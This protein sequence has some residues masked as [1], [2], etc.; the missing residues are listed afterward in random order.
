MPAVPTIISGVMQAMAP[1]SDLGTVV[2][3]TPVEHGRHR[4]KCLIPFSLEMYDSFKTIL[5]LPEPLSLSLSL[6]DD[7][8]LYA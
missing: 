3:L 8:V 1:I 2:D 7:Q 4:E 6:C 5:F